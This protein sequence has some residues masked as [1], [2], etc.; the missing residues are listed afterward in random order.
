MAGKS[1]VALV[2]VLLLSTIC[3]S[4]GVIAVQFVREYF[5]FRQPDFFGLL[6]PSGWWLDGLTMLLMSRW[7]GVAIKRRSWMEWRN[8]AIVGS[9]GAVDVA[10]RTYGIVALPGTT[11]TLLRSADVFFV[12]AL[13][14]ILFRGTKNPPPLI[15]HYLAMAAIVGTVLLNSLGG[16]SAKDEEF[17]PYSLAVILTVSSS[18]VNALQAVVSARLVKK[19]SVKDLVKPRDEVEQLLPSKAADL[20]ADEEAY[21]SSVELLL[22]NNSLTVP[23]AMMNS[24][25]FT[26]PLSL[27][28][29]ICFSIWTAAHQE[30][31]DWPDAFDYHDETPDNIGV[32]LANAIFALVV[33]GVILAR[34]GVRFSK[35]YI[36]LS[37]SA[38]FFTIFKPMRRGAQLILIML[39]FEDI[40]GLKQ[41]MATLC[42]VIGFASFTYGEIL[43]KR[44]KV[45]EIKEASDPEVAVVSP[46][47]EETKT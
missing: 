28:T 22:D 46:Y 36:V 31:R 47:V 17:M 19:Q 33:I 20:E 14:R 4:S 37:R 32:N 23:A 16:G 7:T 30:W 2:L 5:G 41:W 15:W 44:A 26:F 39:I 27:C 3:A 35:T 40:M 18:F 12:V 42:A 10:M 34:V 21:V 38:L 8:F 29:W 43:Q 1:T 9:M 45:F 6:N 25:S 11:Y 13:Q 24:S